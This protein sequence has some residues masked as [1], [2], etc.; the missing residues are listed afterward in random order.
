ML[1]TETVHGL[2]VAPGSSLSL[3]V[4]LCHSSRSVSRC[5]SAG[6][7]L[8]CLISVLEQ[9]TETLVCSSRRIQPVLIS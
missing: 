4:S 7:N 3:L 2:R 8:A 1:D 5:L 6:G 9:E